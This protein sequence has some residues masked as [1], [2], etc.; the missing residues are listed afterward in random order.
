MTVWSSVPAKE[1]QEFHPIGGLVIG[2]AAAGA[3]LDGVAREKKAATSTQT[4]HRGLR[5]RGGVTAEEGVCD[6]GTPI[7]IDGEPD[8]DRGV[9]AN[10]VAARRRETYVSS[11]SPAGDAAA[12]SRCRART[13]RW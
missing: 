4:V 12:V 5:R 11:P 7:S 2:A 8:C 13:R 9:N 3:A 6:N 1:F 10:T